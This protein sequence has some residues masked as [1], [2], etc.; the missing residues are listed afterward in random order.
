MLSRLFKL[1]FFHLRNAK[2]F[3]AK[4]ELSRENFIKIFNLYSVLSFKTIFKR[5]HSSFEE[6][7]GETLGVNY[8][9]L[10]EI[11]NSGIDVDTLEN[12]SFPQL[13][14]ENSLMVEKLF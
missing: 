6:P 11:L 1:D 3:E 2:Y 5:I 12:D 10:P 8:T 14:I 13:K 9:K 4:Y 7:F